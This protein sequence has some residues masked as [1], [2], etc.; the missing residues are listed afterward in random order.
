MVQWYK[1]N[2]PNTIEFVNT[3]LKKWYSQPHKADYTKCRSVFITDQTQESH[4][5]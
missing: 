5:E 4:S 3:D 1:Y 2:M